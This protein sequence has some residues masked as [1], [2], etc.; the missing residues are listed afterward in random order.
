MKLNLGAGTSELPGF[1]PVDRHGGEEV[2][3]L[4]NAD[5]SVA[6]VYASHVLEHFPTKSVQAV[7]AEWV[8]VLKPGGRIRIA[9]PDIREIARHIVECTPINVNGYIYGGQTDSNDFHQTGFDESGLRWYM[10]KCG[11]VGIQRWKSEIKDCAALPISLNLEGWKPVVEGD[12]GSRCRVVATMPEL[13]HT[14]N[15]DCATLACVALG[16]NYARTSGAYFDQGMER[17]LEAGLDREYVVTMDYDTIF[18]PDDVRRLVVLMDRYPQAGAIAA[19]Q[20]QRGPSGKLLIA[21][22][23][24]DCVSEEEC[25][26]DIFRVKSCHFGLTIIRTSVLKEMPKPWLHH[27]PA[28]DGTWGDGR[29]DADVSF[30]HK[31]SKVS[32]VYV[33]PRVNVGHMQRMVTWVGA[34]WA[35]VHQ[36]IDDYRKNGMP[37]NVRG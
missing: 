32:P 36:H 15:R 33:S 12:L 1:T 10:E 35:P 4:S 21:R 30:W 14:D 25:G 34:N 31:M 8:R 17:A 13:N 37:A 18:T 7:I 6:E 24:G 11:L 16:I 27:V 26:S 28:P 2:Y 9:V 29:V 5:D 23:P 19:M 20:A 22:E 3:P